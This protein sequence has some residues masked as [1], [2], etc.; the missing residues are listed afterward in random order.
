MTTG[1]CI[2]DGIDVGKLGIFIE[3]AGD[4]DFLLF[5]ARRE[6][7]Y[8][9]WQEADGM[10]VDL[11][12]IY[13]KEKTLSVT[14][15]AQP[16]AGRLLEDSIY[17]FF[18]IITGPSEHSI[19]LRDFLRTFRLRYLDCPEMKQRGGIVKAGSRTARF[20]VRFQQDDPLQIFD[21]NVNTPTT[22][23]GNKTFVSIDG[24]ELSVYGIIVKE[25][26]SAILPYPAARWPLTISQET[27]TG[28]IACL[29]EETTFGIKQLVV[30]CAMRA[31]SVSEFYRNY[32]ALF[33]HLTIKEELMLSSAA[34][35]EECFYQ[36]MENFRRL[37][38][39]QRRPLVEFDLRFTA[40]DSGKAILLL[41]TE[42]DEFITTE[43]SEYLI[44][45]KEYVI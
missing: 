28:A 45:L 5:P 30:A 24:R 42:E 21:E 19:Y 27:M 6:P 12:E 29:P 43:D 31:R 40:T 32:T 18:D 44:D 37:A 22:P 39:F 38:P 41:S 10:D 36:K 20:T 9:E 14:F 7:R 16:T 25:C 1:G 35:D 17:S 33:H 8:N 11:T 26:Y 23:Y 13:F 3:R 2:I 34:G 15:V 4:G